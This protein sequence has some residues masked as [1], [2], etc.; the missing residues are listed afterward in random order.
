MW[1]LYH[2]KRQVKARGRDPF[3]LGHG[4]QPMVLQAALHHQQ[5]AMAQRDAQLVAVLAVLEQKVPL[6]P[7]VQ[8]R[9]DG[10][11]AQLWLI[12]GMPVQVVFGLCRIKK[13]RL[14]LV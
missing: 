3:A 7:E 11:V 13:H 14:I 6:G 8:R 5:A 2:P 9:N 10:V 12:V 4:V 1:W